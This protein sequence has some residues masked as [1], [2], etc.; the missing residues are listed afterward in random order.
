MIQDLHIGVTYWSVNYK[1]QVIANLSN[2]AILA[3]EA[4]YAGTGIILRGADAAARVAALNASGVAFVGV[5]PN[6]VT[7]FV[8]GRGQNLGKSI[9]HGFDLALDWRTRLSD[10][11]TLSLNATGT[12]LTKYEIAVTPTAPLLDRRNVI[13]NPLKFK[14]R[15]SATLDHGPLSARA[16]LTHVNGYTN[17]IPTVPQKVSSFNPVDLSLTWRVGDPGADGFFAKGMTFAIEARNVFDEKPPYVNIA[18]SGNGSGG[19]D[20]SASDPIGRL[21]AV[22]VRKSF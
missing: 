17:N 13:F 5:P 3:S 14:A 12:Y 18:P 9:T 7:L 11:D 15:V 16:T 21:F 4:Q 1:S 22:S 10:N 2:L 8:D 19:Y 20:A 6:P